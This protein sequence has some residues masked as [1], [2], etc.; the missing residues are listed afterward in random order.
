MLRLI[1]YNIPIAAFSFRASGFRL[2]FFTGHAFYQISGISNHL[3][4]S[5]HFLFIADT[6]S[7]FMAYPC[8]Y[9]S[10]GKTNNE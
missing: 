8:G 9:K 6:R 4:D 10:K 7:D 1:T 2:K 5:A 3:I